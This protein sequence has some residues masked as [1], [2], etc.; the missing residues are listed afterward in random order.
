MSQYIEKPR[1]AYLLSLASG[2]LI[3]SVGLAWI[4]LTATGWTNNW[5][6]SFDNFMHGFGDHFD[7]WNFGGYGYIM[8]LSGLVLG[9]G[10]ISASIMLNRKPSEHGFWGFLIIVLSA[11]SMMGGMGGMGIGL[12]LGIVGGILAVLW[13]PSNQVQAGRSYQGGSQ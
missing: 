8:G 4:I 6:E 7:L 5:F 9:V 10:I 11:M 1:E 2:I 3:A 13:R 12:L